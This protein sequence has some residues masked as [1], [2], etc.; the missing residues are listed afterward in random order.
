MGFKVGDRVIITQ[1]VHIDRA[2]EETL[3]CIGTVVELYVRTPH[4]SS[5]ARLKVKIDNEQSWLF[6]EN[7]LLLVKDLTKL[8]KAIYG[9]RNH[10]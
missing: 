3:H 4:T 1:L 7:E 10:S 6:A 8:E 9:I 2:P 5:Q